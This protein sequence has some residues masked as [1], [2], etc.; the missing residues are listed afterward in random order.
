M[1]QH[2]QQTPGEGWAGDRKGV[3]PPSPSADPER[4]TLHSRQQVGMIE[5]PC[6]VHHA[7]S[8]TC[9]SGYRIRV[10]SAT[11]QLFR[12]ATPHP[13]S[14]VPVIVRPHGSAGACGSTFLSQSSTALSF[15]PNALFG[16]PIGVDARLRVSGVGRSCDGRRPCARGE[17]GKWDWDGGA[18]EAGRE[19]DM[20]G[21][22]K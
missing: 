4:G 12:T 7:T 22:E 8:T 6:Y 10:P 14:H 19:V 20:A 18:G 2:S 5:K 13:P 11:A 17:L 3:R 15:A 1:D 21:W 16:R 9:S